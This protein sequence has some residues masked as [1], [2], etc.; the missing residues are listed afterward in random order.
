IPSTTSTRKSVLSP[1]LVSTNTTTTVT[2]AKDLID[3][4]L[5]GP[6]IP[7]G[8]SNNTRVG[9]GIANNNFTNN[10]SSNITPL[11]GAFGTKP[12]IPVNT[13]TPPHVANNFNSIKVSGTQ[14]N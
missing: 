13:S 3:D 12:L 8:G 10:P 1:S 2:P 14:A 6:I 9:I 4:I 11:N 5:S 7:S